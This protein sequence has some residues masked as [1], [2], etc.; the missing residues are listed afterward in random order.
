[1]KL[2]ELEYSGIVNVAS[3]PENTQK[4]MRSG[5][6]PGE[7]PTLKSVEILAECKYVWRVEHTLRC[8]PHVYL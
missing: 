6:S 3:R 7:S 8:R 4:T 5:C 1:M 2:K